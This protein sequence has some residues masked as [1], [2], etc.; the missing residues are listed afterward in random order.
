MLASE[1]EAK[2]KELREKHGDLEC[3]VQEGFFQFGV[4][5]DEVYHVE[6]E[7]DVPAYF[8]IV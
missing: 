8:F 4:A 5:V 7:D 1:I 3:R 2:L 6:K